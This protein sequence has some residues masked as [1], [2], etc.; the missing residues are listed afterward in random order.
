MSSYLWEACH[1][2]NGGFGWENGYVSANTAFLQ[3]KNKIRPRKGIRSVIFIED[4]RQTPWWKETTSTLNSTTTKLCELII[5]AF[6][7]PWVNLGLITPLPVMRPIVSLA[8]V[9]YQMT[10]CF[11]KHICYKSRKLCDVCDGIKSVLKLWHAWEL[12]KAETPAG[13]APRDSNLITPPVL[14][15]K[16][17]WCCWYLDPAPV[18]GAEMFGFFFKF[19]SSY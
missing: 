11:A 9:R 19:T 10:N 16:W 18:S 15:F 6:T 5:L 13:P 14:T 1:W 12:P 17:H 4:R 3:G 2:H 8:Q 7:F